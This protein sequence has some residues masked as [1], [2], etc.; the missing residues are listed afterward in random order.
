MEDKNY[1]KL[2][3]WLKG[4]FVSLPYGS[5]QQSG[6][7]FIKPVSLWLTFFLLLSAFCRSTDLNH[8]C[9]V[10]QITTTRHVCH[11]QLAKLIYLDMCMVFLSFCVHAHN[12][13]CSNELLWYFMG[14][15]WFIVNKKGWIF[16][17]MFYGRWLF[18]SSFIYIYFC[19]ILP[20][21]ILEKRCFMYILVY[22]AFIWVMWS[23]QCDILKLFRYEN[24]YY[25]GS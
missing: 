13:Q 19:V 6:N 14:K 17:V 20:F 21:L 8:I 16:M 4:R 3:V 18:F 22:F 5:I 24:F 12:F 23:N 7:N 15:L 11:F 10:E 2:V 9:N 25:F 1:L